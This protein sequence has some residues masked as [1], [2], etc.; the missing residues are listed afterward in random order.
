M[1]LPDD[2]YK[3]ANR[4]NHFL[5]PVDLMQRCLRSRAKMTCSQWVLRRAAE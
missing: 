2:G 5:S 4:H 1:P 3:F